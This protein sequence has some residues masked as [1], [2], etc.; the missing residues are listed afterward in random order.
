MI[1]VGSRFDDRIT[2]RLEA[3]SRLE[4]NPHPH[5][6]V[7]INKN[8][9]VDLAI[10]GDCAHVLEDRVRLWRVSAVVPDKKALTSVVGADRQMAGEK[11]ACLPQLE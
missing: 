8:V 11:L 2:G 3:S 4:Q 10:D 5:S 6:S 9:K 7:F 1:A